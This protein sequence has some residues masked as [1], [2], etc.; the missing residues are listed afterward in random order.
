MKLEQMNKICKLFENSNHHSSKLLLSR[1]VSAG[2]DIP[3]RNLDEVIDGF[4]DISTYLQ[5]FDLPWIAQ[6]LN[7]V[8]VRKLIID[9]AI[10]SHE[11][12][13]S[14][15]MAFMSSIF[16]RFHRIAIL[17]ECLNQ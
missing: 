11:N 16:Q 4:E 15:I 2:M 3:E 12:V 13:Y 9:I 10:Y 6:N 8:Q 1:M 14:E 17:E 7:D 5:M